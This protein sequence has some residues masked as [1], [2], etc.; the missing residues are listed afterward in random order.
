M[1]QIVISLPRSNR[2][3]SKRTS[4]IDEYTAWKEAPEGQHNNT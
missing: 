3:L 4:R 2:S 1:A